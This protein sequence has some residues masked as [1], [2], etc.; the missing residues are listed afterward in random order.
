MALQHTRLISRVF[1]SRVTALS[2]FA[3]AHSRRHNSEGTGGAPYRPWP[4]NGYSWPESAD[5][6]IE[7]GHTPQSAE[8]D[9]YPAEEVY[10]SEIEERMRKY[11]R[12]FCDSD[13]IKA[14]Y[15]EFGWEPID[16]R[17]TFNY[18][19]SLGGDQYGP[20][21]KI[22]PSH[23]V[24]P[25]WTNVN[26][27]AVP[28]IQYMTADQIRRSRGSMASLREL[29]PEEPSI[30]KYWNFYSCAGGFFAI[31]FSKEFMQSAGHNMFEG[32]LMWGIFGT[33]A[34]LASDWYAWWHTLLM[35]E[36][37]DRKYFPL[38]Q[39][40]RKYN[41][42]L[43]NFHQKPNEKKL[44]LQMQAYRELVAGKVLDKTLGNRLGR[45]VES[46]VNRLEAKISEEAMTR[47]AAEDQWKRAA[48]QQTV[49]YFDD[50]AVR[51]EFM[52]DALAQF[53]AADTARI[54]NTASSVEYKSDI[55]G[56]Q[57]QANFDAAKRK[58]LEDQRSK[59]TLSPVFMDAT[60]KAA[61]SASEKAEV[62]GQKVS[63][64]A[65][66]HNAVNAPTPAF[67]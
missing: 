26:R 58:Y 2:H 23:Y 7:Q 60:E 13:K 63:E 45:I 36:S 10:L 41:K 21:K 42:M 14:M 57:Y 48:L 47:K 65:A 29:P 54:S 20:G 40:V 38:L 43:E 67:T 34:A 8:S 28:P 5:Y 11:D 30:W 44:A 53:C 19:G 6:W 64:W 66:T 39:A 27:K 18:G 55:F 12:K 3:N 1:K 22:D 62:Y 24:T 15:N 33:I 37:Y 32:L 9:E 51:R 46:T 49:D 25:E 31:A 16:D 35:Q 4:A 50:E 59:G 56:L 61:K 17:A 52:R